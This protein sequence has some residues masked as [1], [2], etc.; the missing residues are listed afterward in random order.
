[1]RFVFEKLALGQVSFS[2][3]FCFSCY[4]LSVNVP[5]SHWFNWRAYVE[6]TENAWIYR[7]GIALETDGMRDTE[8]GI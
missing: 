4:Y 5:F 2:E 7:E 3:Y 8:R 6:S 1:V